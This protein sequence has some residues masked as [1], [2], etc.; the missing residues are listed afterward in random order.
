ML[1]TGLFFLVNETEIYSCEKRETYL[2]IVCKIYQFYI[3]IQKT[4]LSGI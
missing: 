4:Y 1:F 2:G 3:K